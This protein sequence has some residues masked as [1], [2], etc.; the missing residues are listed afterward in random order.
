ML[1][2]NEIL[3]KKVYCMMIELP[4]QIEQRTGWSPYEV[5]FHVEGKGWARLGKWWQNLI[6]GGVRLSRRFLKERTS[7]RKKRWRRWKFLLQLF[8]EQ[9]DKQEAQELLER[10]RRSEEAIEQIEFRRIRRRTRP[11]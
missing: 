7:L 1:V 8:E 11:K 6:F 4:R 5:L 10:V 9:E 3:K 2:W